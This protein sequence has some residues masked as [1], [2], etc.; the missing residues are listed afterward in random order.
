MAGL[1]KLASAVPAEGAVT[2]AIATT[3]N[4]CIEDG[5]AAEATADINAAVEFAG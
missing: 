1:N 4:P 3:L 2:G 5:A